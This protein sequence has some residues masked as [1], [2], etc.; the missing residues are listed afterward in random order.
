MIDATGMDCSVHEPTVKKW[1][2]VLIVLYTLQ[3]FYCLNINFQFVKTKSVKALLVHPL[4][5]VLLVAGGHAVLRVIEGAT[6]VATSGK[7]G[8]NWIV[9]LCS[10]FAGFLFWGVLAGKFLK[11]WIGMIIANAKMSGAAGEKV[12][13]QMEKMKS[14]MLYFKIIATIVF[15]S[16]NFTIF[17]PNP[18]HAKFLIIFYFFGMSCLSI[19]LVFFVA[20]PVA[21]LFKEILDEANKEGTDA[22]MKSLQDKVALF[23]REARNNGISNTGS[24]LL[25]TCAPFTWTFVTYQML[26]GW[27]MGVLIIFVAAYFIKPANITKTK[28]VTPQ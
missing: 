7:V 28:K 13:F 24:C 10:S 4:Q 6:R 15:L 18:E 5:Q 17:T 2:M 3:L 22:K 26:F 19:F 1:W 20:L 12:K 14:Q 8:D 9:S 25:F 27:S 16:T 23:L 11:Q 21:N